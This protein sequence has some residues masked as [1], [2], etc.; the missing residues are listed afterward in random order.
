MNKLLSIFVVL[1]TSNA[2]AATNTTYTCGGL[3]TFGSESTAIDAIIHYNDTSE[4]ITIINTADKTTNEPI[5]I[6]ELRDLAV[7]DCAT[8]TEIETI[9]SPNPDFKYYKF[10]FDYKCAGDESLYLNY[11]LFCDKL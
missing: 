8:L 11:K 1:L 3:E 5:N 6:Q 10:E 9:Q 2:F 4:T 7:N